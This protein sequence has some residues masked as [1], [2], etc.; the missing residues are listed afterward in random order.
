VR[1]IKRGE[2]IPSRQGSTLYRDLDL[3]F[4]DDQ[5]PFPV[6]PKGRVSSCAGSGCF[7]CFG[8]ATE[9]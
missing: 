2:T 7:T 6:L 3:G 8:R 4:H 9:H 1:Q 5:S